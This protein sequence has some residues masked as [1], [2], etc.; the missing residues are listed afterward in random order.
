MAVIAATVDTFEEQL[1]DGPVVIDF[2]ATW[3][4][5]CRV[6][7]PILEELSEELG[8]VKFLSIDVDAEP[9]LTDKYNV[10][11]MPTFLIIKDGEVAARFMGAQPK[12][13]IKE[14]IE[15]VVQ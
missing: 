13:Q 9:G 15:A 12:A 8:H 5:P 1:T 2:W 10:K 4:P 3:C 6:M 7:S 14:K 11:A